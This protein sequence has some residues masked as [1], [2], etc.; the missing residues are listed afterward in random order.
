MDDSRYKLVD[1]LYGPGTVGA[2]LLTLCA[3]SISWT[4][5][6]SSRHK[7][8]ISV[9]FVAALLLPLIAAGHLVFLLIR[10]PVSLAEIITARAVEL[11]QYESAIEAPLNIC[12]TFSVVALF[13]AI[14]CGPWWHNI[15]KLKR[16]GLVVITGLFSWAMENVMFAMATMKGI[17]ARETTLSRPY[18]FLVTTIVA[19]TW[20]CLV[21]CV[22]VGS[23]TWVI[24]SI[25][26]RRAQNKDGRQD[27]ADEKRTEWIMSIAHLKASKKESN[28]LTQEAIDHMNAQLERATQ[29]SDRHSE[30][31][32][33][34]LEMMTFVG[35]FFAPLSAILSLISTFDS[36]SA[37]RKNSSA[38]Y[39]GRFL[40]I[41]QSDVSMSNLDQIA[42]LVGG[43]IVLLA[44]IRS[45]YHSKEDNKSASP[46]ITRRQS[47]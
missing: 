6:K 8:T 29:T 21:I 11:Q 10:L 3:V 47:I 2:W 16:L 26:A 9:D 25:N 19:S 37:M 14:L 15:M 7:D 24:S 33:R 30:I 45:A 42:A 28:N 20:A 12:E 17:N 44:A 35:L 18:L 46:S 43:V 34:S 23:L 32:F 22:L 13:W 41:P 38:L 4:F 31:R 40:L 1:S 36:F 27:T 5:N 39:S